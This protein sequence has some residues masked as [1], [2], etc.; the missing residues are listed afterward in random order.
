MQAG[1]LAKARELEACEEPRSAHKPL[2][3]ALQG[4]NRITYARYRAVYKVEEEQLA[5][6][7]VLE[8]VKVCFVAAGKREER[9]KADVYRLAEK[10]VKYGFVD[11][12]S[13]ED[14]D[15]IENGGI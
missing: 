14:I 6:G 12:T 3:G 9:S 8:T 11:L 7:D 13:P 5:S 10:I 2:Q 4:F 15:K 1:L